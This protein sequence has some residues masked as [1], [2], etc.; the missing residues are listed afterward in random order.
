V[1]KCTLEKDGKKVGMLYY[2]IELDKFEE[3]KM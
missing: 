2:Q 3:Q 1:T